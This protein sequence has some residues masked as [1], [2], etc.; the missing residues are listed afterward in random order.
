M[1]KC[2]F[3]FVAGGMF[4]LIRGQSLSPAVIA[5]TGGY[6]ASASGSVSF[7]SGETVTPTFSNGVHILTQGFQQP[8]KDIH[9]SIEESP[10]WTVNVFPNPVDYMLNISIENSHAAEF[11]WEIID[12]QGS[13]ALQSS[14]SVWVDGTLTFPVAVD[15]LAPATYVLRIHAAANQP[16]YITKFIKK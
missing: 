2:I 3:L 14:N 9:S 12:L 10:P 1:K 5:T 16:P 15:Q 6:Q 8:D 7:T 11:S 13:V 4:G